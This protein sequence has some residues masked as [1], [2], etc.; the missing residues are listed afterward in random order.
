[1]NTE[2]ERRKLE[3]IPP[4]AGLVLDGEDARQLGVRC[5]DCNSKETVYLIA[6]P[7]PPAW[8]AGAYCYACLL[9]RCRKAHMVPTPMPQEIFNRLK[10]DLTESCSRCKGT[11][12]ILIRGAGKKVM[13]S[14]PVCH[15]DGRKKKLYFFQK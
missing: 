13:T 10:A 11:G 5:L 12:L 2:N 8:D 3:L 9:K 1:M 15:G 7:H 14:C 6:N 4:G